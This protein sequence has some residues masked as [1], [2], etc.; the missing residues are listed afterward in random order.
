LK[1]AFSGII[2]FITAIYVLVFAYG[3]LEIFSK[4]KIRQYSRL[5]AFTVL[6]EILLRTF[7]QIGC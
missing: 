6:E 2:T 5:S 7:K 4:A 1:R 3:W